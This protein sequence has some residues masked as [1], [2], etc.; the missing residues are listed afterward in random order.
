MTGRFAAPELLALGRPPALAAKD[1]EI[2]RSETI[3]DMV[4]RFSASGADY[5]VQTL[6]TDPAI[7]VSEAIAYRDLLR[8]QEIDEAVMQTYLGSATGAMLDQRAA[9][10]GVLRRIIQIADP[11]QGIPEILEDDESVRLRARLA[12]EALSVAG[13]AGAYVFHTLDAH[14]GVFDAL[15]IGPETGIVSPG[16]V[17]VVVQSRTNNGIPTDSMIDVIADRLDA[18]EVIYAN[19]SSII[20]PVRNQQSVRPLGARVTVVGARPLTYNTTATLYVSSYGDAEALRLEALVKLEAYQE[21]SRRIWQRVS[22]EGRQAALSLVGVDGLPV[23]DEVVV[24]ED[25]VV[26]NHLEI[27]VPGTITLT[28]VVR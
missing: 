4:A 28:T 1:Y 26:P 3:A 7:V 19:G 24:T 8:R 23:I 2:I 27:P 9:D 5:D 25:D 15:A 17:L 6:E 11:S 12:W 16:E 22:K 14:E 18:Y 21:R 10:Y 13:P 20:R